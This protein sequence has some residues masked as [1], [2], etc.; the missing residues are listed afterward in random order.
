MRGI[1]M[2]HRPDGLLR[3]SSRRVYNEIAQEKCPS[4]QDEL[5]AAL[6]S[7]ISAESEHTDLLKEKLVIA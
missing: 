2:E 1:M 6:P 7:L 3:I 4:R 5:A